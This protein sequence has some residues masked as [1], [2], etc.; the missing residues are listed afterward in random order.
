M[1]WP[2]KKQHVPE[3]RSLTNGFTAEIIAARE[4][5]ISGRRGIGELT[6][7]VQAC[8]GLWE[9][10]FSIAD[11]EGTDYLTPRDLGLI[12]RSLALR[13][14]FVGLLA[15]RLLPAADWDLSTRDGVPMAYRLSMP[16]AG[17]GRSITALAPEVLHVRI[18]SDVAAPYSGQAPLR[19]AVLTAGLLYSIEETLREIYENAP[20]GSKIVPFPESPNTDQEALSRGFRGKRGRMLLRESV[21]V[22]AAGGATPQSDWKPAELSPDI[23]GAMPAEL[24]R[25]ARDSICSVYGVLPGLLNPATTGPMVREAQRHLA[26]WVLQ[27]IAE[28]LA[29]EASEKLGCNIEIDVVRPLA[30]FD[31]GARARAFAGMVQGLVAAKEGGLSSDEITAAL[32]FI[33]QTP[34]DG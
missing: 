28:I 4:S 33:D 23:E 22:T 2:F 11:V 17:G 26:G 18:G 12:A 8:V 10:G 27:P 24:L 6:G 34:A 31:H 32:A 5:H 21:N 3:R 29:E 15:D 7:T 20:I 19:R 9:G 25:A 14:E 13:G 1:I 30:A 16:D